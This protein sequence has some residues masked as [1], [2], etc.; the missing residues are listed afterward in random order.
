MPK[1][2][3]QS[4]INILTGAH[5]LEARNSILIQITDPDRDFVE[6][7][8]KGDFIK[9]YQFKFYDVTQPLWGRGCLLEPITQDQADEIFDILLNAYDIGVDVLV[10]CYAGLCRSGAV[11]EVGTIMGFEAVHENRIPNVEVKS[12][13]LRAL[14]ERLYV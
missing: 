13:L 1:I 2:E 4:M 6:P 11:V 5:S 12:K 14:R 9:I 10:H 7:Y 8:F 3:N